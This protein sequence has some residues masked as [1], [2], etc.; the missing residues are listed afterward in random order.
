MPSKGRRATSTPDRTFGLLQTMTGS[1]GSILYI[2]TFTIGGQSGVHFG[3]NELAG[4]VDDLRLS[5]RQ[6]DG[7]EIDA[8][9][10]G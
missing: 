5:D 2:W 9:V 10:N 7:A 6:F 8:L 3:A 1:L 4:A